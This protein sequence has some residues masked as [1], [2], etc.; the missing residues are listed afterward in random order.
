MNDI[1]IVSEERDTVTERKKERERQGERQSRL[2]QVL[3]KFLTNAAV[4]FSWRRDLK[5]NG[6]DPLTQ[7]IPFYSLINLNQ[8]LWESPNA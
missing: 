2:G 7:N 8:L 6:Y 3:Y 1:V 5:S 4:F